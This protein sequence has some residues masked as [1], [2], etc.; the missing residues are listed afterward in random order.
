MKTPRSFP[1]YT[2]VLN[3]SMVA[4]VL[5]YVF[6]GFFGFVRYGHEAA[7]SITLNLPPSAM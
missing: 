3:R 5:M 7:G 1:G 6:M 4:I 2:G